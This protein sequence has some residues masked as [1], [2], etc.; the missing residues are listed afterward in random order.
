MK[1]HNTLEIYEEHGG[2]LYIRTGKATITCFPHQI[3]TSDEKVLIQPSSVE[4]DAND[5]EY[6]KLKERQKPA[7]LKSMYG[8]C[9]SAILELSNENHD[10]K[11]L[12]KLLKNLRSEISKKIKEIS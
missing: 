5:Q 6:K 10:K 3:K 7:T 12:E 11:E 9:F 1:N 2:V 4:L 8:K